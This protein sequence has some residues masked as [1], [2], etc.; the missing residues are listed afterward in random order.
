MKKFFFLFLISSFLFGQN[1]EKIKILNSK[2]VLQDGKK[3][4]KGGYVKII[5]PIPNA[6]AI[7]ADFFKKN[8]LVIN[9]GGFLEF[10]YDKKMRYINYNH[11]L[12]KKNKIAW[13]NPNGISKNANEIELYNCNSNV[14]DSQFHLLS[15]TSDSKLMYG[16]D[17]LKLYFNSGVYWLYNEDVITFDL[18]NIFVE[19]LLFENK[20][21]QRKFDVKDNKIIIDTK[22]FPADEIFTI[23]SIN[24][25][26]KAVIA[27]NVR[28]INAPLIIQEV[29][30]LNYSKEETLQMFIEYY[31]F[32]DFVNDDITSKILSELQK[33]IS[34]IYKQ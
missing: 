8:R 2:N 32:D 15:M 21:L 29:K 18:N 31:L 16:L 22:G 34:T 28:I 10:Y 13:N 25:T 19:S 27:E 3:L 23:Y 20:S 14:A 30:S 11:F 26:S 12:N 6:N 9:N 5:T 17:C 4:Q 33:N 24:G 7:N 1:T